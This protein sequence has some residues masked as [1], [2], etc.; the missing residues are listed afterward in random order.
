[1]A[2][3]D[4]ALKIGD[5]IQKSYIVP[6][7]NAFKSHQER[8]GHRGFVLPTG[9]TGSKYITVALEMDPRDQRNRNASGEAGDMYSQMIECTRL[10]PAV[11]GLG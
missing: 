7:D 9:P 8:D 1:M 2:L 4:M 11:P 10:L 3:D 5:P 6:G